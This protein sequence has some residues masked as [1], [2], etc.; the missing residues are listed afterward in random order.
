MRFRDTPDI[1]A[2][3]GRLNRLRLG[4]S[5]LLYD[6]HGASHAYTITQQVW[7]TPDQVEYILPKGKEQVTLVSCI[8]NEVLA[9]D[10]SVVNMT[11]RLITIAEPKV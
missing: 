11:H 5:I 3:F 1:P 6:G 9:S 7:A 10:G 8:G 2:P 4:A